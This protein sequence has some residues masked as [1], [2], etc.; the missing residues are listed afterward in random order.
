[1]AIT[2]F[3]VALLSGFALVTS[4]ALPQA[5]AQ[6]RTASDQASPS[7]LTPPSP[8]SP[9]SAQTQTQTQRPTP[10]PMP[11]RAQAQTQSQAQTQKPPPAP[12]STP[13]APRSVLPRTAPLAACLILPSHTANIGSPLAGVVETVEVERG[14]IV[15]RGDVLVRLRA[16]VE[17][18]Q[19]T[20]TKTRADSEAELRGAMAARELALQRL[21]RSQA[22]LGDRFLSQQAVDQAE[23]EYRLSVEKVSQ[24]RDAL[25]VSAGESGVSRAQMAQRLIRAPFGGIITERFAQ[26]G[27]RYEEK[28]L[29][30]IAA[31]DE[32]RVEV[33]APSQQFGRVRIGQTASIEPDL[34]DQPARMARV[35]QIDQVLDPASNTFRIRLALDNPDRRLPAGLRCRADFA[36]PDSDGL[37]PT[38]DRRAATAGK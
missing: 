3:A 20:V 22:L 26:P 28:P 19:A 13:T 32:L 24:A 29:L 23:A 1:M 6:T 11:A 34:P 15:L 7:L 21:E 10:A 8:P 9:S 38:T 17:R 4:L 35:I 2:L 36:A 14:D 27:E 18:A 37:Q 33:V 12:P 5:V 16:D 30:R 31:I 25:R